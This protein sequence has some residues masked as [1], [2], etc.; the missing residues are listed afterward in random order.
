M[1]KV[2][3]G[4]LVDNVTFSSYTYE[5]VKHV[6]E[7]EYFANPVI[8]TGYC[9]K[10]TKKT[11][12][13]KVRAAIFENK[14]I[15]SLESQTIDSLV[16]FI[17]KLERKPIRRKKPFHF[18]THHVRERSDIE[19]LKVE[20]T[21]SKSKL[22]LEFSSEQIEKISDENFDCIVRCGSG[23]L[24]GDILSTPTYGVLSFH[25][26]DNRVNRGGPSGF[27]EVL[28]DEPSSGFI[29]QK[30]S[31]EL[32]GGQV[33][34]RGNI[35]TRANW[36][37]NNAALLYK[38]NFFM[39]KLL[40]QIAQ[41]GELPAEEEPTLH[42]HQLLKIDKITPLLKY[43]YKVHAKLFKERVMNKLFGASI[44]RW[45]VAYSTHDEFKKSLW[46][47]KEIDNPEGSFLADPFVLS[48]E[49]RTVIFVEDFNYAARKGRIS[50]YELQHGELKN[51]GIVL[52]EPYH[53]SFPFV[54][55]AN[56]KIYMIPESHEANEIRLYECIDF[57]TQWKF[58][59]TLMRNVSAADTMIIENEGKWFLLTNICSAGTTDH[60]SELH[61]FYSDR[62]DS[63]KWTP[64]SKGNP[65]IF[66]SEKARNGG[67]FRHQNQ[68]YR[69]NQI[70]GKNHY[71]KAFG[72]NKVILL[73]TKEY[74]ECR[75]KDV[76]PKFK[77]GLTCTHHFNANDTHAVI[78]FC[79][80]IKYKEVKN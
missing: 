26:G 67:F 51:H 12:K 43:L 4:F 38:S 74:K 80:D 45:S 7:S 29:I 72:V 48:H 60:H 1:R 6:A 78:D 8:I 75:I 14:L 77:D 79:R 16:G 2:K 20:G 25:H 47:Y 15:N 13:E 27:W 35:M 57:P 31:N 37:E 49:G 66:D 73:N 3:V 53:L 56:K 44:V 41:T 32:D 58:K 23:I 63:Q 21:W 50:V 68:L 11:F 69:I 36:M 65:V 33:L 55:K 64:L 19:V 24:R 52:E 17:R 18:K 71:G 62:F 9:P 46:R 10:P 39:T 59:T 40:D 22:F 42:D 54:F 76:Y 61:V 34:V 5:L 30:L 28:N 70:Q